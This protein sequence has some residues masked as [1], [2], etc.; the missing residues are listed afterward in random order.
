MVDF[1]KKRSLPAF[2]LILGVP[3]FLIFVPL[4]VFPALVY[5][6]SSYYTL[7]N[8]AELRLQY[9]SFF[10]AVFFASAFLCRLLWNSLRPEFASL[11]PLSYAQALGVMS[12]WGL[13]FAL[14][15]AMVSGARELMGPA[16]SK[17][18]E[19]GDQGAPE[20]PIDTARLEKLENYRQALLSYA[21]QHN[22][23]FPINPSDA[24]LTPEA[25]EIPDPCGMKYL[26]RGP[27]SRNGPEKALVVEPGVFGSRQY[28]LFTTG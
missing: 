21:K 14:A 13:L 8:V 4:L 1:G 15:L 12:L 24:G 7:S 6:S 22:N 23:Q 10:L 17:P 26:Y 9:I 16:A 3:A 27:L 19:H 2:L 11:P 28:V 20:D 25:M 5:G 18:N